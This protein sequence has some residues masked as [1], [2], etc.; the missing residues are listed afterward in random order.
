MPQSTTLDRPYRPAARIVLAIGTILVI[1]SFPQLLWDIPL[2]TGFAPAGLSLGPLALIAG[3][4][5]YHSKKPDPND[6][7]PNDY[8]Y[9]GYHG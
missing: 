2:S 9:R 8:D 1:S 7:T 3:I 5:L 6:T 4:V